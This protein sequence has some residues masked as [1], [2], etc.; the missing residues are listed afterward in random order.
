M[1]LQQVLQ[2]TCEADSVL[3]AIN[4]IATVADSV[5]TPSC[6]DASLVILTLFIFCFCFTIS[7]SQITLGRLGG[8]SRTFP[9]C[10]LYQMRPSGRRSSRQGQHCQGRQTLSLHALQNR[11][12]QA[13]Y[14]LFWRRLAGT[15]SSISPPRRATCRCVPHFGHITGRHARGRYSQHGTQ[16]GQ[17]HFAQSRIS[18]GH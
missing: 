18:G 4:K 11:L 10:I 8:M 14:C 7:L 13:R 3:D 16:I 17:A 1:K 15:L 2:L 6:L 5:L 12:G 9:Y